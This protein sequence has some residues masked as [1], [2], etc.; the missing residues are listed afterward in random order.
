MNGRVF[1]ADATRPY[2]EALA[3]Q[4]DRI[5]T[6]GTSAQITALAG[7]QT[8]RI[9]VGGRVVIPGINDA[10]YHLFVEPP[11]VSLP[12]KSMDPSWEDVKNALAAAIPMLLRGEIG[13]TI[14]DDPRATRV[15]L[16]A[17][18][19]DHA[20]L[21]STWTQNSGILNSAALRMLGVKEDEPDPVGGRYV[22]SAD[23][24]LTGRVLGFAR[25]RLHRRLSE[26]ATEATALQET[27]RF[28]SQV[29]RFGITSVQN[30]SIPPSP[31]RCLA[32]AVSRQGRSCGSVTHRKMRNP[33]ALRFRAASSSV[34]SRPCMFATSARMANNRPKG[35]LRTSPARGPRRPPRS[36]LRRTDRRFGTPARLR[37]N[38]VRRRASPQIG[39]LG[40]SIMKPIAAPAV[41]ARGGQLEPVT[42]L[43]RTATC[44]I[45]ITGNRDHQ[46]RW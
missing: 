13:P 30:M 32:L 11:V 5:V 46:E 43:A 23:G 3:I 28:L 12:F 16:D 44:G 27:R 2:L 24:T 33:D 25:F 10:H 37:L 1:T 15:A 14:L 22:R 42:S 18:A 36:P 26:L 34:G 38:E 9:D 8:Q 31:E 7:P 4:G 19:S 41:S 40:P 35:L 20:V 6:V 17:L 21:L 45:T 39:E 29:V